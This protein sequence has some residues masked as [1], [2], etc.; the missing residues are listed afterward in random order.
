MNSTVNS[1][2]PVR[3]EKGR[4]AELPLY[5]LQHERCW[6][7]A[8]AYG[9]GINKMTRSHPAALGLQVREAA[10]SLQEGALHQGDN[11]SKI[12]HRVCNSKHF[13]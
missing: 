8:V 5:S 12:K 9:R 3:A 13:K 11:I 1:L 2:S 4:R 6:T 10:V 7:P